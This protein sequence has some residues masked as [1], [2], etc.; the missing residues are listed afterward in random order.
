MGSLD[1][2]QGTAGSPTRE[3]LSGR[4]G[5]ARFTANIAPQI[6]LLMSVARGYVYNPRD[7][8][9]L[10]QETLLKAYKG[11]HSLRD[12]SNTKS[13]LLQILRR[14]WIDHY[15][16]N[17]RR[18]LEV[19]SGNFTDPVVCD[20]I[21]YATQVSPS[22]ETDVLSAKLGEDLSCAFRSLTE[23]LSIAVYYADVE[24]LSYDEIASIL[25]IPVGTVMSRIHRGR[26]R[27][28]EQLADSPMKVRK[29]RPMPA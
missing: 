12:S 5:D 2:G 8:E 7:A 25:N 24:G 17:Q 6:P 16:A 19:L 23:S 13:W 21:S 4:H 1:T 29:G 18:P 22:A 28:R 14:T 26:K 9:D 10:V 20:G 11:F 3:H 27:L 15:R